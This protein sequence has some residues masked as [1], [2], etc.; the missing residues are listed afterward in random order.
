MPLSSDS[1]TAVD[2]IRGVDKSYVKLADC[3]EAYTVISDVPVTDDITVT[4]A[5]EV[6]AETIVVSADCV[7]IVWVETDISAEVK[8]SNSV[9]P[10]TDGVT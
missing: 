1:D 3:A 6:A 9:V 4:A 5:G 2:G 8:S 10:T 7:E